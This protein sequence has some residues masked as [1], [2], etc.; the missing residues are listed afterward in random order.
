MGVSTCFRAVVLASTA[1]LGCGDSIEESIEALRG[2]G[3]SAARARERL[4]RGNPEVT[5]RLLAVLGDTSEP[6]AMRVEVSQL[7]I[8]IFNRIKSPEIV[9]GFLDNQGDADSAVR[10]A[11]A[12]GLGYFGQQRSSTGLIRCL[13]TE[14]DKTV[15]RHILR[16]L[17]DIN[18]GRKGVALDSLLSSD[19]DALATATTRFGASLDPIALEWLE[20]IAE[21]RSLGAETLAEDGDLD[22]ALALLVA[23]RELVPNSLNINQ[24]L[25]RL[26]F[27]YGDRRNGLSILNQQGLVARAHGLSSRP[28]ID[29]MLDDEAWRGL[30]PLTGFHRCLWQRRL[31][32]GAERTQVYV[33]RA[34]GSLFFGDSGSR[35]GDRQSGSDCTKARSGGLER[36]LH[37]GFHRCRSRYEHLSRDRD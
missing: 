35:N 13:L 19:V 5:S 22:A 27:R 32:P 24:K 21:Q 25:G 28:V 36:R 33:G 37:R 8:G 1:L 18:T 3:P 26:H 4:G 31:E 14:T 9:D 34:G 2:N 15:A 6:T 7:L 30:D 11:I 20:L 16:A 12:K 23:C 10:A 29:G 17:A